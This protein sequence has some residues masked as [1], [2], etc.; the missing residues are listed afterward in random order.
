MEPE[1]F[2]NL[3]TGA[4]QNLLSEIDEENSE[5]SLRQI[6]RHAYAHD[7]GPDHTYSIYFQFGTPPTS[8][9]PFIIERKLARQACL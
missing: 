8:E 3:L 4:R 2:F 1:I 6:L 5:L 9:S 7:T